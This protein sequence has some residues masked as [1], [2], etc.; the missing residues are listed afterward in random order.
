MAYV[1]TDIM[2]KDVLRMIPSDGRVIGSIGCGTAFTEAVLIAQ[3]RE[4]HGVDIAPEAIKLASTR[5]TTARLVAPDNW[6]AFE[7]ESLDGLILADV[8]E[9]I[10]FAWDALKTFATAVKPGGWVVISVPNMRNIDVL[11]TFFFGGDWPEPPGGIFDRTH[12]H[13]MSHKRL[14]RWCGNANLEIEQWFDQYDPYG[15]RRLAFFRGL[16][17]LTFRVFHTWFMYQLQVR[18]RRPKD[19][20]GKFELPA[21]TAAVPTIDNGSLAPISV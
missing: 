14:Q 8:I 1:Y 17:H 11:R 15:P 19:A 10:P 7:K 20:G 16:D 6:E 4:V 2:R 3:G 9:H 12:V 18:C 21:D 13:M 5:I